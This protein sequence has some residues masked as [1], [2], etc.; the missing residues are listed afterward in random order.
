MDHTQK[1]RENR[2]IFL[3]AGIM[4]VLLALR[5]FMG[6]C[7][8][9]ILNPDAVYDDRLLVQYSY[10]KSHFV[11]PNPYS[12]VKT[13]GF[14]LFL[15]VVELSHLPYQ[16][17]LA[18]VYFA[19]SLVL[20]FFVKKTSG[21]I[22]PAMLFFAW[23]LFYPAGFE[24]ELAYHLYRN[25]LLVPMTA[26]V[27]GVGMH[28]MYDV[29]VLKK[30]G[31]KQ[32]LESALL[33]LSGVFTIYIKEDGAWL[34]VSI[35]FFCAVIAVVFFIG[36]LRKK[37]EKSAIAW[38]L[39]ICLLP[40]LCYGGVTAAYLKINER[41][42]GVREIETRTSGELGD[43]VA[44]VY[45][46]Q[47]DARSAV[48]WAPNDAIEK[49]F[50]ASPTLASYP[51][52]EEAIF[53]SKLIGGSGEAQIYGDFLTWVL[54]DALVRT[55]LYS[56]EKEVSDLFAQV[57]RELTAAF[58]DGTLEKDTALFRPFASSGGKTWK[59]VGELIPR[60]FRCHLVSVALLEY[61]PGGGKKPEYV[62]PL[63]DEFMLQTAARLHSPEIVQPEQS[64]KQA[65]VSRVISVEFWVYRVLNVLLALAACFLFVRNIIRLIR[66]KQQRTADR[67]FRTAMFLVL[68]GIA[69]LYSFC[70][71]WFCSFLPKADIVLRFYTPAVPGLLAVMY[72]LLAAD[73][74]FKGRLKKKTES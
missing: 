49:A 5:L 7:M 17:V 51:E 63:Q 2:I 6:Y 22:L 45:S 12:L 3:C 19:A 11:D 68:F 65:A 42:F 74:D 24:D 15:K 8:G 60:S 47:S 18:L 70:I 67:I 4:L 72:G 53:D 32:F 43:F 73:L 36:L 9:V 23:F 33:A 62:N 25:G 38:A 57:N 50:A 46:I 30:C 29:I 13:L 52:L 59:E 31:F 64:K 48:Y 21:K 34:L 39:I 71:C 28:L 40:G 1:K 66:K 20:F 69:T 56:S 27:V 54:R 16:M 55:D 35:L 10:L 44:N 14:P 41:F 61:H 26:F 37:R 58:E